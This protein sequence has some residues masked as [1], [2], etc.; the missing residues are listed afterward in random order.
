VA[1]TLKSISGVNHNNKNSYTSVQSDLMIGSHGLTG[2]SAIG[3]LSQV[4]PD[5]TAYFLSIRRFNEISDANDPLEEMMNPLHETKTFVR[6]SEKE[7][8]MDFL[9]TLGM[10]S[11]GSVLDDIGPITVTEMYDSLE[12]T[13]SAMPTY[14]YQ[15]THARQQLEERLQAKHWPGE[16]TRGSVLS[17]QVKRLLSYMSSDKIRETNIARYAA[18]EWLNELPQ[19]EQ[20]EAESKVSLGLQYLMSNT[21]LEMHTEIEG[22]THSSRFTR[23][24]VS[25][26]TAFERTE[27]A[28]NSIMSFVFMGFP[29]PAS[30]AQP[31]GQLLQKL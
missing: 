6:P 19:R 26:A 11:L 1:T 20:S 25:A 17:D 29:M 14:R 12:R 21:L 27:K 22:G 31:I 8:L 23:C 15:G 18:R 16:Q 2:D 7:A 3:N 13:R 5:E 10:L 9:P 28:A 4:F 24:E 30:E